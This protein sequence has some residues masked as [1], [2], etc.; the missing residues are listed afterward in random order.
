[1]NDSIYEDDNL[2]LS[3]IALKTQLMNLDA[4]SYLHRFV[5]EDFK[6]H[7]VF[8]E[9]CRNFF[10]LEDSSENNSCVFYNC[11]FCE[12]S[13]L[14][15]LIFSPSSK[16]EYIEMIQ[17]LIDNQKNL[18]CLQICPECFHFWLA[19]KR[20]IANLDIKKCP[21][22]DIHYKSLIYQPAIFS[23]QSRLNQ[24]DLEYDVPIESGLAIHIG[25]FMTINSKHLGEEYGIFTGVI[26]ELDM[27]RYLIPTKTLDNVTIRL[28]KI[29]DVISMTENIEGSLNNEN[30]NQKL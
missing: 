21:F 23:V 29:D 30:S 27:I 7:I 12:N 14:S 16:S 4:N 22:C 20:D 10:V 15:V 18:F 17:D 28:I 11:P 25:K 3:K 13:G 19:L 24:E 26:E 9:K 8:C 6:Y 5:I 2:K 1:M